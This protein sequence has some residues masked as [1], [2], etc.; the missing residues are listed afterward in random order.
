MDLPEDV[1]DGDHGEG[2]EDAGM[3]IRVEDLVREFLNA[4][5]LSVLEEGGLGMAVES[6]VDKDDKRALQDFV[7][8]TLREHVEVNPTLFR[9]DGVDPRE[10]RRGRKK[11]R[12]R[13]RQN[14]GEISLQNRRTSESPSANDY[15]R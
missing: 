4:Q 14:Q 1:H 13:N 15:R 2:N 9:A 6:F 8:D 3:V 5:T 12:R 11:P 10:K 7:E